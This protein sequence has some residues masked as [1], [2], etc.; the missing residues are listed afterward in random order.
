MGS[1]HKLATRVIGDE[2]RKFES[3]NDVEKV[4]VTPDVNKFVEETEEKAYG[5]AK[6]HRIK[7]KNSSKSG[8]EPLKKKVRD[9]AVF[10][11]SK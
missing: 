10:Y 3:N 1:F 6:K 7:R 11:R 2:K 8:Y 5:H 9:V 4:E